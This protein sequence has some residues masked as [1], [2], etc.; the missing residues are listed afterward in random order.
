[1]QNNVR[2]FGLFLI[3]LVLLVKGGDWFVEAAVRMAER[4]RIPQFIIGATVVS[5]A[6]TLPEILVSV[7]AA[8]EGRTEIAV[9]N[10]IGSVTANT[11]LIMAL[12][13]ICLPPAIRRNQFVPEGI[14]MLA[15]CTALWILLRG[16]WLLVPGCAVL[17][18]FF[19]VFLLESIHAAKQ[20]IGLQPGG[21][22]PVGPEISM[23]NTI[24]IFLLGA[25]CLAVGSDLLVDNGTRLAMMFGVSE[26]AIAVTMVAVG[27]SLPELVTA[28]TSITKKQ[29]SLS[30]GNI[31]G[32]NIIDLTL[33]LPLC[34]I[35][36]GGRLSTG[37]QAAGLDLPVCAMEAAIAVIPTM[38][39]KKFSR[40]QG[41]MM[42]LLYFSYLIFAV[43]A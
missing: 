42:L 11:G 8:A 26:R 17:L 1:M 20:Q 23:G 22:T 40:F 16:G 19:D 5:V 10:A 24:A 37:P 7:I 43:R 3:G 21:T 12:C 25:G 41:I 27:T 2:I 9:G 31:L 36:S 28:I 33:I 30:V 32:A 35:L 6:T 15:S 18:V 34:T 38:V 29:A 4:F 13:L 39:T 14:L